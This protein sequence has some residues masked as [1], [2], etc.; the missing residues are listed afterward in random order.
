[1][2]V[3]VTVTAPAVPAGVVVVIVVLLTTTTLVAAAAPKVT[4]APE[5]KFVPVIVTD[6]PPA[7]GPL[8]GDT[9]LTVGLTTYVNPLVRLPLWP[10]ELVT[11]TVTAPAVPAGV[12]AVIVVLLTTTTFVAAAPAKVTASPVAKFVHVIVTAVPPVVVP[13]FGDTLVTVGGAMYVNPLFR[14][15]FRPLGLVTVTVAPPAA[16]AGVVAVIEV[17]LI[18]VTPVAAVPPNVTV[19]P[20]AKSMPEIVRGVPPVIGPLLA[21]TIILPLGYFLVDT[22][23]RNVFLPQAMPENYVLDT[24]TLLLLRPRTFLANARDLVTL[25]EAV[26]AQAGRYGE[27]RAPTVVI[28]G[29]ADNT[30][31]PNIHARPFAKAVPGARLIV[32]PGVGHMVQNAAPERVVAEVDAILGQ[33]AARPTAAAR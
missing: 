5:A 29:D 28:T 1:M 23:A 7:V 33:L 30:V 14:L 21:Y 15:P 3:T 12:V 16:P 4:V 8:L 27:I 13:L 2:L 19:A 24:A 32:L 6:V 18:T 22:G 10:I 9:L 11:V 20:D 25:K 31:S 17:L 26:R